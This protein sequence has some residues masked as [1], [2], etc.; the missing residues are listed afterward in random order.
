MRGAKFGGHVV[1]TGVKKI[2]AILKNLAI[3]CALVRTFVVKGK[4]PWR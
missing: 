4:I 1:Q 3:S 2:S